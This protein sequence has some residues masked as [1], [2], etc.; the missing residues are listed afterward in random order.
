MADAIEIH[1]AYVKG[2]LAG[3]RAALGDPPG[4]PN[5]RNPPGLAAGCLE[6]AIYHG[7]LAFIRSLLELGAEPNYPDDAGSPC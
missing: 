6:Y 2:D 4:F 3:L 1:Q 5:V 7:P